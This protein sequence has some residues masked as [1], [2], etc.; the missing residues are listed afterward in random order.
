[1]KMPLNHF[2][3]DLEDQMRI[4]HQEK[5]IQM[6]LLMKAIVMNIRK[7]LR[8]SPVRVQINLVNDFPMNQVKVL[9]LNLVNVF[10]S[11]T[12]MMT[13]TVPVNQ[14]NLISITF[15]TICIYAKKAH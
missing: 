11:T 4:T 9:H 3:Y 14:L 13:V 2:Q 15:K 7:V 1:M 10:T 6:N 8:T 5:Q 12:Q